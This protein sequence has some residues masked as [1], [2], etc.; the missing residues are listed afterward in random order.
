VLVL[1]GLVADDTSTIPL[2]AFVGQLGY[3]V[4][5][6]DLGR[7]IGPTPRIVKSM[8]DRLARLAREHGARVTVIGW[9]LGG[10][11]ARELARELPEFVRQVITLGSPFRLTHPDQ[12]HAYGLFERYTDLHIDP[13]DLPPPEAERPPL[14]VPATAVYSKLDGIVAW[15]S[16]I[17]GT[18]PSHEN[19]AVY[20]SHLGLGYNPSVMWVIS[21]RL[22]QPEGEWAPFRP[23]G[24]AKLLF[25]RA[26]SVG[27]A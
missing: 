14:P 8:R 15:Q 20:S 19:V 16:C 25:P 1:P 9:S 2:R 22:A 26:E 18:G 5:G 23:P 7:N 6:W 13:A 12:S 3:A 17:D 4:S 11:Y 21:D 10:I 27:A 24:F